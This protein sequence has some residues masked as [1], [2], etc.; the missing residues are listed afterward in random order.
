MSSPP[1][2]LDD[3]ADVPAADRAGFRRLLDM[4]YTEHH[5]DFREYKPASLWRRMRARMAQVRVEGFDT[6]IDYLRLHATEPTALFNTVLINVTGF[7]RDAE[8]WAALRTEAL[9]PVIEAATVAGRLRVW[10]AGCSTGEETYSAA[11]VIA[12]ALGPQAAA[13][14]VKIYA[15]DVDEEALV[16]A[17]QGVFRADQLKDVSNRSEERRVGK[18]CRSRWSPYH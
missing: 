15:T 3:V 5:F 14:D 10:S 12:D 11:I 2:E 7:F 8:A 18:E 13:V 17:R 6:Y 4:L 16:T 9:P 1:D